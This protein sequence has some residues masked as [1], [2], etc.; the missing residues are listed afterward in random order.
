MDEYNR[1]VI[2]VDWWKDRPHVIYTCKDGLYNT[3]DVAW[4]KDGQGYY[5]CSGC[6]GAHCDGVAEGLPAGVETLNDLIKHFDLIYAETV[7]CKVC[8]DW[9]PDDEPCEHLVWDD[10]VGCWGGSGSVE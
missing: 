3:Y 7:Y 6:W 2:A 4:S 8:D 9:M 1:K 5:H 10:E